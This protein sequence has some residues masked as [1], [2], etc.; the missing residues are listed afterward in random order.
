M[1]IYNELK[2]F[3]KEE[4]YDWWP[5]MNHD[6]LRMLDRFRHYWGEPVQISPVNGGLG[7]RDNSNSFHNVNRW[8]SVLAADIFPLGMK[9]KE[10]FEMA[11]KCA[12]KA[13]AKGIGLYPEAILSGKPS[14]MLHLDVGRRGGDG[15]GYWSAF[16]KSRGWNYYSINKAL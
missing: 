9:T 16:R 5:N 11:I 10:D 13:G 1:E 14:P 12:E 4:F 15:M 7:R 2:Y 3:V 8:G 6:L